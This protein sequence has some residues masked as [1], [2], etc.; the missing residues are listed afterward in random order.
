M[1]D[2]GYFVVFQDFSKAFDSIDYLLLC[3]KLENLY[4]FRL[5]L[6]LS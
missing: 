5:P 4:G 1:L 2:Q 3:R 6:Y